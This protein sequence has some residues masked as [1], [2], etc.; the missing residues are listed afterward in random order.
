MY[1]VIKHFLDLQD[2]NYPYQV[3]DIYP[4]TGLTVSDER[5]AELS[6]S[7]NRQ[8]TPLIKLVERKRRKKETAE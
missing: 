4:H 2:S 1:K 8:G 5:I 3:G 6:G 7:E